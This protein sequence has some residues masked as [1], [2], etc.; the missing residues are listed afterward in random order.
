MREVGTLVWVVLLVIGVIGSMVSSVRRQAAA[1]AQAPRPQAPPATAAAAQ[2][3]LVQALQ[4]RAQAPASSSR[5]PPPR[6]TPPRPASAPHGEP[7]AAAHK[8]RQRSF[9][10]SRPELVRAV[11]AAEVLGK[12]RGLHDEY[13]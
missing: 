12:P 7:P 2:Q 5:P 6:P 9:F 4:A 8:A 10:G 3:R 1:G 13:R 11:I